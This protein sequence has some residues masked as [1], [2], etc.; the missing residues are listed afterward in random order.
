MD[1]AFFA[2]GIKKVILAN[3]STRIQ[4]R[5]NARNALVAGKD[6]F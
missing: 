1:R 4:N 5:G 3:F 6:L 2:S